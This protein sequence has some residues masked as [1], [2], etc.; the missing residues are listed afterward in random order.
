M[1]NKVTI[2]TYHYV[3]DLK[4]SRFNEIK[5]LDVSL[6]KEQVDYLLKHYN[7]ITMEQLI[8]AIDHHKEFPAKSALLTFD[9]GYIDYFHSVFPI[10]DEKGIQGSFYTPVEV[11]RE[12][13]VLDVNKIHFILASTSDKKALVQDIFQ[14]LD[15]YR[16]E[17]QLEENE[18]YFNKLTL[19]KKRY[20]T[21]EVTFVKKILQVGIPENVR[22]NI[23]N[24]LFPRCI[25]TDEISFS[26]ELY[27]NI[28]HIKCL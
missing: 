28:D 25:N 16:E 22:K 21:L 15:L 18:Y 10:L 12:H 3:R 19:P 27:M 1:A 4:N 13:T 9:D 17:Y 14:Q 26:K 6:F 2:I 20:D 7:I 23:I 5:G 8:D 24:M 11:L